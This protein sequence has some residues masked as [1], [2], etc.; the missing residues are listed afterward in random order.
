M[1]YHCVDLNYGEV[2]KASFKLWE[3]VWR[4]VGIPEGVGANEYWRANQNVIHQ[5]D[6]GP[7]FVI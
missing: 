1:L 6:T 7:A 5:P 4:V 3:L 2:V